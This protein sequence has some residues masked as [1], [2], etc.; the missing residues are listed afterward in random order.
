MCGAREGLIC[1]SAADIYLN[2]RIWLGVHGGTSNKKI[3]PLNW[4]RIIEKEKELSIECWERLKKYVKPSL[5]NYINMC[6]CLIQFAP[7]RII[8][9]VKTS[10]RVSNCWPTKLINTSSLC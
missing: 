3:T 10:D 9:H 8:N 7:G 2:R 6:F 5:S 4:I 1:S